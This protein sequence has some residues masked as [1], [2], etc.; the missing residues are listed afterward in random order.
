MP[1]NIIFLSKVKDCN[2]QESNIVNKKATQ[3]NKT[4]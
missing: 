2:D 1:I 4:N 3:L